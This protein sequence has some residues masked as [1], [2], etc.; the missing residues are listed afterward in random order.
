MGNHITATEIMARLNDPAYIKKV[1]EF[2]R[3]MRLRMEFIQKS[4]NASLYDRL[5]EIL[6]ANQ[7]KCENKPE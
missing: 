2:E 3:G 1:E 5:L 6:R 7:A 4:I